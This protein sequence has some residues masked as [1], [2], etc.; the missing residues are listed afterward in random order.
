MVST[1]TKPPWDHPRACGEHSC[2][3][4]YL[5]LLSGSSRRT[6]GA[7]GPHGIR[8]V[9]ARIIPAHAGST[10]LLACPRTGTGDHPRARGEHTVT[11]DGAQYPLGSSPR[12]RGSTSRPATTWPGVP[13][14]PRSRGEH[15]SSVMPRRVVKGSSPRT[16]GAQ[17]VALDAE[18]TTRIIPAHA[19]STSP[20]VRSACGPTDH[21]R[22]AGSTPSISRSTGRSRDH[23]RARGEHPDPPRRDL[24]R[25]VQGSSPRT[26][27][28]LPRTL[29]GAPRAGIIP[30]H[31]GSTLR[32]ARSVRGNWDHP[33]ARGEHFCQRRLKTDPLSSA[34]VDPLGSCF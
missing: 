11:V 24:G 27:G 6:R 28:A 26:R 18:Q 9:L 2:V 5:P 20:W 23:P 29:R 16:R 1:G 10:T 34:K 32:R 4:W 14:H 13:D 17:Q 25:A 12:T 21:P 22:D 8:R 15:V 33:R 30:A 19:G 3:V 31:A 7:L